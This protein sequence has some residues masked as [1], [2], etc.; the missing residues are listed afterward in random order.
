MW[1]ITI[2]MLCEVAWVDARL[3]AR[4]DHRFLFQEDTPLLH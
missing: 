3:A 1:V 2:A 4:N